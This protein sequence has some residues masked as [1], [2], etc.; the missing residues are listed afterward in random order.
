FPLD[1][2]L[3]LDDTD[4]REVVM[5][6]SVD[7][8][9]AKVV[10]EEEPITLDLSTDEPMERME[11]PTH[12]IESSESTDTSSDEEELDEGQ[13][14]DCTNKDAPRVEVEESL[15]LK[16]DVPCDNQDDPPVLEE[17]IELPEEDSGTRDNPS[18]LEEG[19]SH[20]DAP[21]EKVKAQQQHKARVKKNTLVNQYSQTEMSGT[22]IWNVRAKVV[23]NYWCG[24]HREDI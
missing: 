22:H 13:E 21:R 9:A 4:K 11:S 19:H 7:V 18:K 10:V 8:R 24:H 5:V 16:G 2:Q 17:T 23:N 1:P 15:K 6:A 12:Q 20:S 14:D 3:T